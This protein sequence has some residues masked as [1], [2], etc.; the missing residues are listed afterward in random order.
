MGNYC[1]TTVAAAV[2]VVVLAAA[3]KSFVG[4]SGL[5]QVDWLAVVLKMG[6]TM[7][8]VLL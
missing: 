2:E 8:A 3:V 5:V 4:W 6:L 1:H 7:L